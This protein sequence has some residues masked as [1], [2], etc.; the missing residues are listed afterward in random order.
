[1][2]LQNLIKDLFLIN[3]ILGYFIN[4]YI[5]VKKRNLSHYISFEQ[6]SMLRFTPNKRD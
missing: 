3:N 6:K 5:L 1:M 2:W 4:K